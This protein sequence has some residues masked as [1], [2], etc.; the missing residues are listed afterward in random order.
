[1]KITWQ[2]FAVYAV[3]RGHSI[4]FLF[5]HFNSN[6]FANFNVCC[7]SNGNYNCCD[8][9]DLKILNNISNIFCWQ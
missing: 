7:L 2:I 3:S 8:I 1:M 5:N 9:Y 6:M 4:R